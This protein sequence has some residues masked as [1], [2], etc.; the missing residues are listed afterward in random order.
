MKSRILTSF[1][2][3]FACLFIAVSS[4]AQEEV[5]PEG[6]V[7]ERPQPARRAFESAVLIDQQT[8]VINGA[9]TLEWNIQHR[10]GPVSNGTKDL[11]GIFAPSNIR[12]GFSYTPIDRIGI[13]FGL[14][15]INVTNPYL[16]FNAKVKL[17]E[18]A[19]PGGSPVNITAFGSASIDTRNRSNFVDA[20][21]RLA[22]FSQLIFSRRVNSKFSAQASFMMSHFNAVDSLFKNDVFGIG[23][24]ARY[25]VSPQSSLILE[26][27][28]PLTQHP[29]NEAPVGIQRDAGPNMNFAI[30]MEV[31][32]S[33]HAFQFFVGAARN[34]LPQYNLTYNTNSWLTESNGSNKLS[35]IAGF[36]LTRLWNF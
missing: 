20:R 23:F 6:E 4:R 32:T 29:I 14:S 30:G 1:A 34:L 13:G 5:A 31:A 15:K 28:Q 18:Q 24:L 25:K 3:L 26:W 36:N 12:M 17:L 10:F 21:H 2:A 7:K 19:G 16:D 9:K 27:T 11:Y 33:S 8:D 35:F 22:Y